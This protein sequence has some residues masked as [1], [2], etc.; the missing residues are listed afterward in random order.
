ML[1]SRIT[2]AEIA[3]TLGLLPYEDKL[4][5]A[6]SFVPRLDR[7]LSIE[8]ADALLQALEPASAGDRGV[9]HHWLD[10]LPLPLSPAVRYLQANAAASAGHLEAAAAHW[11]GLLGSAASRDPFVCLQG[12]RVFAQL[13]R[14]DT[15]AIWLRTA[16]QQQPPYAWFARAQRLVEQVVTKAHAPARRVRIGVIGSSTTSFLVPVLRALCFR[17][18]IA[19]E[20]Y[21]GLYGA[22]R[23]EI[24]DPE[25]GLARF[26]PDVLII[27]THWRDLNLPPVV[28]DEAAAVERLAGEYRGLW[29][30]ASERLGC[31]VIQHA[32]DL[33]A[34]DSYGLL[35]QRLQGSRRRVVDRLNL[36]LE[37]D[38]PAFASILDTARVV[39]R[40]GVDAW[41][42]PR[43]WQVSR[44]HPGTAALPALAEEQMAHVKAVLGLTR[45]VVVCDLDN[46]LWGGVIGEDGIDGIQIAHSGS[47]GHLDLQRYLSE[48]KDRGVLLAVCSKNNPDDA[49]LPFESHQDMILRLEDFAAFV[50][51]WDDKV[52][53]IRRIAG[54]LRLGLDSFVVLDDNPL[55]RAWIRAELPEVA[56]VELG[57]S[58]ASYAKDLDRGRYFE[59]LTW[60]AEDRAR[61]EQYRHES[62]VA[63]DRAAA[64]SLDAFLEGLDMRGVCAAV[65]AENIDRVVQLTNKTNQ[66]NLTTKRY[67]RPQVERLIASRSEWHGVFSLADRY[68]DHGIIGL[69]FCTAAEEPDCWTVDTWL[70]SCR[71][72][73]R[74]FEEFMADSMLRAARARGIRTIY[75]EYRATAKN[76]LVAE[77]YP[78]LG[79]TPVRAVEGGM[80]YALD[81]ASV[82]TPYTRFI[83]P[84]SA[85]PLATA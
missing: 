9:L 29:D 50:A 42:D 84:A 17:D 70:M 14:W 47:E 56:V 45:K 16:L 81:V 52:T 19:A 23:Q 67:T 80:R 20:L 51:N 26:R 25:S 74:Q 13:G 71:V 8:A 64:G 59:S 22:F 34:S 46:T 54:M 35:A 43:L 49:R 63:S 4:A 85:A 65:S 62:A 37:S 28:D 15:A 33:P 44:Q 61:T 21:E 24:L 36:R 40:V 79:F 3:T 72:L 66:F 73:G 83:A 77:L 58:A 1:T 10:T 48:L 32:F 57:P 39:A 78:R 41:A 12:A 11:S 7:E 30:A 38:A 82:T 60:S 55:E 2:P 18:G 31:H 76:E 69:I 6:A 27:A 68:G 75:G 53:N 5:A